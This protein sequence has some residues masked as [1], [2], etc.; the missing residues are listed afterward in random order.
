LIAVV[1]LGYRATFIAQGFN[2]T[3][4]G[5]LQSVGRRVV[6]GQVPYRDFD[7][8]FPRTPLTVFKEAALQAVLGDAYTLLLARWLFAVEATLGSVFAYLILRRFTSNRAAL[9]VTIPT[10][11]FSV[12]N[13]YFSNYTFDADILAI[14][15]VL[16]LTL[17]TDRRTWPA[18][19]AG[20]VAGLSALAKPNYLELVVLVVVMGIIGG[21]LPGVR[22]NIHPALVGVHRHWHRFAAGTAATLLATLLAFAALGALPALLNWPFTT[23]AAVPGG[24]SLGFALWQDL[25]TAFSSRELKLFGIVAVLIAIAALAAAPALLRWLALAAVPVGIGLYTVRYFAFGSGFLP[26]S[27]GLLLVIDALAIGVWL[28]VRLPRLRDGFGAEAIRSALPPVEILILALAIQYFAQFTTTGILY[29]YIGA[30]LTVPV[31]LL[32]LWSLARGIAADSAGQLRQLSWSPALP[33]V[34]GLWITVGSIVYVRDYVYFDAPRSQLTATFSTSKLAG[35]W[36]TPANVRRID[37]VVTM[38]DRY[39]KPGDPI[40]VMPDL[41]CMYYLTD[42]VN[43]TRQDW[44]GYIDLAR[45]EE[46]PVQDLQREPPK[47]VVLQTVSEFDWARTYRHDYVIDY[48]SSGMAAIYA[49]VKANYVQVASVDDLMVMVPRSAATA[50][51]VSGAA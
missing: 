23:S 37:G 16:L 5:W 27:V 9:L 21:R 15:A 49:Y 26:M 13:Y 39:S 29:S 51:S 36:S 22:R 6:L 38:I 4:E 34:L 33:A 31:A 10:V 25:P 7:F 42:R 44:L 50:I 28:A 43:P 48:M 8:V 41:S 2:A 30:Y 47:V 14:L 11:F 17:A 40:L 1:G 18:W 32:L 46:S 20:V 19:V 24:R 12:I 35:I 3:D 45:G